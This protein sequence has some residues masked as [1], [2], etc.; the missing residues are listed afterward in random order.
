MTYSHRSSPELST[1]L[2]SP[3]PRFLKGTRVNEIVVA[4]IAA[5]AGGAGIFGIVQAVTHVSARARANAA[6]TSLVAARDVAADD[7]VKR[8]VQD[9]I[10]REA[11]VLSSLYLFPARF[12]AGSM[13]MVL[14]GFF[15]GLI[16]PLATPGF[17]EEAKSGSDGLLLVTIWCFSLA[18]L[19]AVLAALW[20][21]TDA[22]LN[23]DSFL[24]K[25]SKKIS[26]FTYSPPAQ[27]GEAVSD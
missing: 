16:A 18:V 19:V 4:V 9:A 3:I 12:G 20:R 25:Q 5:V 1:A 15:V 21:I 17:Q 2:G 27:T 22:A 10:D 13:L 26:P 23:R 6:I 24:S 7:E 14:L 11:L 8:T